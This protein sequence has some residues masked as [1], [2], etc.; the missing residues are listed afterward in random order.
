MSSVRALWAAAI[1]FATL[2]TWLLFD[3]SIGINWSLVSLLSALGLGLF[4][5]L[6]GNGPAPA[7]AG[8]LAGVVLAGGVA[9]VTTSSVFHA[10][11]ALADLTLLSAAL[12]LSTA[13]ELPFLVRIP[14]VAAR[15]SLV[16]GVRRCW[17]LL[18]SVTAVRHRAAVRGSVVAG[19]VVVVFGWLLAGADPVLAAIRDTLLEA[20]ERVDLVTRLAFF[21]VLAVGSLGGFG[22]ALREARAVPQAPTRPAPRVLA[23]DTERLIVLTAVVGLFAAFLLLQLSC[24]FGNPPALAGSGIT[25]AEYA[26]RGFGELTLVVT[27]ATLLVLALD[28]HALRGPLDR[29]VRLLE[30]ALVFEL[31]LLLG[32]AFRRVWLY[33]TAYGFTTARL[34]AQTYMIALAPLLVLLARDALRGR[35]DARRLARRVG[36]AALLAFLVLAYGNHE[37]W[38]AQWNLARHRATGQ[39]DVPYLVWS[40]SRDGVP[41]LVRALETL[42]PKEREELRKRL[43][44]RYG[45]EK[46]PKACRWFEWKWRAGRA[47]AALES[48]GLVAPLPPYAPPGCVTF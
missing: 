46:G 11:V 19:G 47:A 8:L 4:L 40:L 12:L 17:A 2:G 43:H 18:D 24:L 9:A 3:A 14:V 7:V 13:R 28:R 30:L 35:Q 22:L 32:S 5:R 10:R 1:V 26:R 34:Y 31:E 15:H 48:A 39:L 23:T 38:I 29:R 27:L 6:G 20:L 44:E 37:A 36:V 41:V 21:V 16:E 25:F 33:E 42:P 45:G